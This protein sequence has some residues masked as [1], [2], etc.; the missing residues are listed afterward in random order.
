MGKRQGAQAV[1]HPVISKTPQLQAANE[2][3]AKGLKAHKAG[4]LAQA[5]QHYLTAIRLNPSAAALHHVLGL[6]LEETGCYP[7]ALTTLERAAQLDPRAADIQAHFGVAL[8]RAGRREEAVAAFRRALAREPHHVAATIGLLAADTE[9]DA[10]SLL[11]RCLAK[12]PRNLEALFQLG[13]A[14]VDAGDADAATTLLADAMRRGVFTA[15]DLCAK[16]LAVYEAGADAAALVMIS[17]AATAAPTDATLQANLGFMFCQLKLPE[18]GMAALQRTIALDPKHTS[19]YI[20]LGNMYAL[21]R[22]PGAAIQQ[23]QRAKDIEPDNVQAN[24]YLCEE[25]RNICDWRDLEASETALTIL[26]EHSGARMAPF[27]RLATHV[28]PTEHLRAARV[29]TRGLRIESRDILPPAPPAVPGR[30]IRI[31][32]L[33]SD[34]FTHAT[35]FLAV[36]LFERHDRSRFETFAYSFSI[37]D[38][39]PMRTRLKGA[40]EHFV[41]VGQ[42]TNLEAAQRIRADSIDILVDLKGYTR[43]CRTEILALRPAPVQVNYLGY[44]GTMGAPFIDYIIG[45]KVVTPL[46]AQPL[47]DERIVQ[48]PGS[49]QPND[50]QRVIAPETPSRAECELPDGAFV[51]CCFNNTYK[52]TP[53]LFEIWMRLLDAVPD[54]VLWLFEANE[55]ARDNLQYEAGGHG[56]DP[57]RIIFAPKMD[58]AAHLA[59]HRHADLFLDTQ[60]YNAHTTASDALWAGVPIVTCPGESFAGRVAASLLHAVGL[61]EL[62]TDTL[63]DYEALALALAQDPARLAAVKAKLAAARDTAPLF[64]AAAYAAGIEAAYQRMHDLRCA[65]QAPEP[66]TI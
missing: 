17:A 7:E 64:D 18:Q 60:P 55:I 25:R 21:A 27:M 49:Y 16:G 63:A 48:L 46:D 54:S 45:D 59:R 34:L 36:E 56:I 38:G 44:P 42:L 3:A 6:C 57:A 1:W 8:A 32:Y 5:E 26:L 23:F 13:M 66:I 65:G 4:N 41:E 12:D 50:R 30:R 62:V 33:S 47:Y 11:R 35:A 2:A 29:W 52:I 51:F 15:R 40:F 53:A 61:P 14:L 37:E 19:A 39:S 58:L 20:N 28:P 24:F 9:A 22:Q 31:G 43:G 10:V